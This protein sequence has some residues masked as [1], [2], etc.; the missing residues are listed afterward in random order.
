[1]AHN[2]RILDGNYYISK[3]GH[4]SND[5][6]TPD[7]PRRTPPS[8]INQKIVLGAGAYSSNLNSGLFIG[9]GKVKFSNMV[10]GGGSSQYRSTENIFFENCD[11][12]F[13]GGNGRGWTM[14]DC[15]IKNCTGQIGYASGTVNVTSFQNYTRVIFINSSESPSGNNS[16]IS[17]KKAFGCIFIGSAFGCYTLED[18]Y[19]DINST[20]IVRTNGTVTSP[21]N[22]NIQ[23]LIYHSGLDYA[24]GIGKYYAIKDLFT[25]TPQDNGYPAGVKWYSE[26]SFTEDGYLYTIAGRDSW[27]QT[28]I[29][30][31]PLFNDLSAEDFTL[32]AASPHIGRAADGS[33]I[34][35]T[36]IAV[37]VVNSNNGVGD[38]EIIPGP[39]IDA[40]NPNSY[41]LKDGFD[42]GYIDY[43]QKIGSSPLI[44]K[45][46]SPLS[47]L[48]FD[49]DFDGGTI[50]NNNVPDSEPT[51]ADYPRAFTSTAL[52]P[53]TFTVV[54]SGHDGIVGEFI[55]VEGEIR[56][57]TATTA[58]DVTVGV[59]FR[60]AVATGLKVQIGPEVDIAALNPNRLTYKMRTS[61]SADK[62]LVLSDWDN[63]IDPTYN[64]SGLFFAQEWDETP[65][66]Y[67][68]IGPNTIYGAGE[69]G[70]PTQNTLN[71]VSAVWINIRVYIRNNYDS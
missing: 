60:A 17:N 5:G 69:S 31:D 3:A 65:G 53:D 70:A 28:C 10:T 71:E 63:D 50:E 27:T 13:I 33:N 40:T 21:K 25:G 42:E 9:D 29:N 32:Q 59:A 16:S 8:D 24:D 55:K 47:L 7:T 56:Q 22:S 38:L 37:S 2:F 41:T 52:A 14:L 58:T 61:K 36:Q 4:D 18:C 30:R 51:S 11:F 23:G 6:L 54:V 48:N 19:V 43:I 45:K 26:A 20:I 46:I 66:Y 35:G 15:I 57:I 62:P 12:G 34:G 49:S 39:E 44:L 64:S 67:I 68:D 1:M